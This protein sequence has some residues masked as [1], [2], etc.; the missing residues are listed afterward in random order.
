MRDIEI[1]TAQPGDAAQLAQIQ[2]ESW[3]AAFGGILTA[4]TLR[5]CTDLPRCTREIWAAY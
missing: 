1:R 5:R 2:T 3:K 4:E